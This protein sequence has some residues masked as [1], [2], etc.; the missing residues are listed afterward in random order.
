MNARSSTASD[1]A[2]PSHFDDTHVHA[3]MR[4]LLYRRATT[5]PLPRSGCATAL[6]GHASATLALEAYGTS[7]QRA[8]ACASM[9][10]SSSPATY[11]GQARITASAAIAPPAN[12]TSQDFPSG[13]ELSVMATA[14]VA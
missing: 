4:T 5:K 12:R 10:R 2:R 11:A 6:R 9:V 3:V 14:G 13:L 1:G 7:A 8:A